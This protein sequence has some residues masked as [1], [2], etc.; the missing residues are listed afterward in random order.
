[1][2]ANGTDDEKIKPEEL[3]D[4]QVPPPMLLLDPANAEPSSNDITPAEDEPDMW[5]PTMKTWC[6]LMILV[7][8]TIKQRIG[9]TITHPLDAA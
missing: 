9:N 1:M 5:I 3:N 6:Q 2:T 7:N 4:Y 8:W